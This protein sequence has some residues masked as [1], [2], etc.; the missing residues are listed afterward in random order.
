MVI[1][2]G[3][4]SQNKNSKTAPIDNFTVADWILEKYA[5]ITLAGRIK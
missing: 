4:K 1:F 2:Y 5:D 3:T